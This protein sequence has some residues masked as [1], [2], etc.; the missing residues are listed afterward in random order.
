LLQHESTED[1][2]RRRL[3]LKL[4]QNRITETDDVEL[5]WSKVKENIIEAAKEALGQRQV[6]VNR[7]SKTCQ[8]P[9]FHE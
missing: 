9:W 3:Q 2:Y 8:T 1:L 6:N 5:S 7:E 4:E